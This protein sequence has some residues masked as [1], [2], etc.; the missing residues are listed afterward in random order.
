MLL[1]LIYSCSHLHI[2]EVDSLESLLL[3]HHVHEQQERGQHSRGER[4]AS[5]WCTYV[6]LKI[7]KLCRFAPPPNGG[8]AKRQSLSKFC[9]FD[10]SLKNSLFALAANWSRRK[11]S[12]LT[13]STLRRTCFGHLSIQLLLLKERL[14]ILC[15]TWPP[16]PAEPDGTRW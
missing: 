16:K 9:W 14:K 3:G 13:S 11:S 1:V 4:F 10:I 8:G 5:K 7:K 6:V 15:K 2:Y 12:R